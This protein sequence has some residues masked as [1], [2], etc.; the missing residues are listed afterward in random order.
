MPMKSKRKR[1]CLSML[2]N[3]TDWLSVIIFM[4]EERGNT[5]RRQTIPFFTTV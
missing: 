3:V 4:D 5:W 2:R 1:K